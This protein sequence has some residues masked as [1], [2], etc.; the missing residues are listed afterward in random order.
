[1]R[2]VSLLLLW[3]LWERDPDSA[4][5]ISERADDS[6]STTVRPD[7]RP[8]GIA[9]TRVVDLSPPVSGDVVFVVLL[10]DVNVRGV[11]AAS[12]EEPEDAIEATQ[13]VGK[14]Q[15]MANRIYTADNLYLPGYP[16]ALGSRKPQKAQISSSL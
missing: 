11:E 13:G 1:M 4:C 8:T 16:T 15:A 3:L 12:P 10:V 5:E 14:Q 2:L 9:G 7:D 6:R